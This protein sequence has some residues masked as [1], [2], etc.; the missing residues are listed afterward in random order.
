ME[1]DRRIAKAVFVHPE[2][3][4]VLPSG[5]DGVERERGFGFP[6][7]GFVAVFHARFFFGGDEGAGG[8]V[9][10]GLHGGGYL[11]RFFTSFSMV[12]FTVGQS[13]FCSRFRDSSWSASSK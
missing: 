6:A 3:F 13:A 10:V 4:G 12:F 11:Y 8:F 7:Y 2:Q 5:D 9:F 1:R